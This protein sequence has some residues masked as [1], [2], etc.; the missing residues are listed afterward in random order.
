MSGTQLLH[1]LLSLNPGKLDVPVWVGT[2]IIQVLDV[3]VPKSDVPV[4]TG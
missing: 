1:S 3:P 4:S 2:T